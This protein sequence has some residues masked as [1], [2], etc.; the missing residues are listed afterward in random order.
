MEA[1]YNRFSVSS[2]PDATG[3]QGRAEN[4]VEALGVVIQSS[5]GLKRREGKE[6][7][8]TRWVPRGRV[9]FVQSVAGEQRGLPVGG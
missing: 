4:N 1:R 6:R 7:G 9:S 5:L 2:I 3:N 8:D